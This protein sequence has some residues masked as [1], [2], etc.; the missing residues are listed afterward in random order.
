MHWVRH[1]AQ[2]RAGTAPAVPARTAVGSIPR[3][4]AVGGFVP[5]VLTTELERRTLELI[6][7]T[8]RAG[9]IAQARA[10]AHAAA[11][12]Y[13]QQVVQRRAA[14]TRV[15]GVALAEQEH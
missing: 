10:V 1:E 4:E 15:E 14:R 12:H 9:E 6:A 13:A 11:E 8:R 2:R 3:F 5:G 7:D